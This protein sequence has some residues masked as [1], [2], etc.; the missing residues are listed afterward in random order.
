MYSKIIWKIYGVLVA[1]ISLD[2][3]SIWFKKVNIDSAHD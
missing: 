3:M 1:H 2:S